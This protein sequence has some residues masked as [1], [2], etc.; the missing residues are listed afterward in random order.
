MS[1]LLASHA[2]VY[3]ATWITEWYAYDRGVLAALGLKENERIAGFVHIGRPAVPPEDRPRPAPDEITTR[4]GTRQVLT[5]PAS[6]RLDVIAQR[7]GFVLHL[8]E[9]I[10]DHVAD[11]HN[12]AHLVLLDHRNVAEFARRHPLH[13]D[14]GGLRGAARDDFARHHLR[15]RLRE[16]ARTLLREHAHDVALGQDADDPAIR[17]EHKQRA[18]FVFGERAHRGFERRRGLDRNDVATL[19][20]ENVLDVHGSPPRLAPSARSA[21]SIMLDLPSS[22]VSRAIR[23]R[24][25]RRPVR[26]AIGSAA[27]HIDRWVALTK[28]RLSDGIRSPARC[29]P[30]V[31][32]RARVSPRR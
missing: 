11:R 4:F 10:L 12:S 23:P 16:P 18:D 2:L 14:A 31:A 15:Q 9:P 5:R 26:G 3:G 22:S 29:P 21:G 19:G 24:T 30:T 7:G 8:L 32:G 28:P 25:S 13:D 27:L 1:L 17:A 20:G 6:R